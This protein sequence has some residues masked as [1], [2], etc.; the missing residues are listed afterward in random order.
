VAQASHP[1]MSPTR[2]DRII[3]EITAELEARRREIDGPGNV[4][5]VIVTVGMDRKAR[6]PEDVCCQIHTRRKARL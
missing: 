4:S 1:G 5:M 2:T 6:L 3:A